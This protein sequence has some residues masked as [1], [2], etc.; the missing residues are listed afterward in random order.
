MHLIIINLI[1]YFASVP[2]RIIKLWIRRRYFSMKTR[3]WVGFYS[4]R[5]VWRDLLLHPVFMVQ[6]IVKIWARLRPWYNVGIV[7]NECMFKCICLSVDC[8][9]YCYIFFSLSSNAYDLRPYLRLK[10]TWIYHSLR[11]TFLLPIPLN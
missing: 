4:L 7:T 1:R 11:T 3:L 2:T 9:M 6:V 8:P 5:V 10:I